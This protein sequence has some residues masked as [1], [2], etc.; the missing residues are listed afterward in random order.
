MNLLLLPQFWLAFAVILIILQIDI[1]I[2]PT[3]RFGFLNLSAIGLIVGPYAAL[4]L[5]VFSVC[6]WQILKLNTQQQVSGKKIHIL[7][8]I[9]LLLLFICYK[10]GQEN[11]NFSQGLLQTLPGV[12]DF[13]LR[14][15]LAI[16]FSYVAVRIYDVIGQVTQNRVPLLDP[17]SLAAYL[18][19]LHMLSAGPICAYNDHLT[20]DHIDRNNPTFNKMLKSA[21]IITSGLLFKFVL[22]EGMRIYAFGLN[23]EISATTW[24]EAAYLLVYIFFDFAGY[25]SVALGLG[26][27]CGIPTPRN[28]SNPFFAQSVT[29]FWNRWHISLGDFVRRN[30][31]TPLQLHLLRLTKGH[32]STICNL[33][34]LLVSFSFV[35]LWHRLNFHILI[36][37]LFMGSIMV[38]EKLIRDFSLRKGWTNFPIIIQGTRFLGPIYTFSVI[39]TGLYFTVEEIL[40]K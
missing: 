8:T 32:Y 27:L 21:N 38:I 20:M 34:V 7:A 39:T 11:P 17:I 1:S 18:A 22:A 2:R 35:A 29:D 26:Q 14:V 3:L 9:G 37:A 6:L 5:L 4:S 36:W 19:P 31:F 12:P 10:M 30:I 23:G 28:F 25:S 15:F 13:I 24:W 33:L 40:G 16:S